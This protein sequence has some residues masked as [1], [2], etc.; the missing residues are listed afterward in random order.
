[1]SPEILLQTDLVLGYVAWLLFF[2]VYIWPRLKA[3]TTLVRRQER[4]PHG[5]KRCPIISD[6]AP[7]PMR[8]RSPVISTRANCWRPN[9][10]LL[11]L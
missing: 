11:L 3:M 10:A 1:M 7:R 6:K 9:A 4:M 2:G 8:D 5:W